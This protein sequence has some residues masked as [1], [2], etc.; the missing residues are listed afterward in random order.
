MSANESDKI[1]DEK[2]SLHESLS[3]LSVNK[4]KSDIND[5]NKAANLR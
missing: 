1:L 3:K 4:D 2:N 5:S